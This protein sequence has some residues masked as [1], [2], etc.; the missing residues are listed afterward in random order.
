M[1]L[2]GSERCSHCG[3]GWCTFYCPAS[4]PSS[5]YLGFSAGVSSHHHHHPLPQL[6]DPDFSHF[7]PRPFHP[8]SNT[9][10]VLGRITASPSRPLRLTHPSSLSRAIALSISLFL[11]IASRRLRRLP[12]PRWRAS[13]QMSTPTC[14]AATGTTTVSTSVRCTIFH[15]HPDVTQGLC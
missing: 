11:F 4:P 9:P 15:S 14:P 6:A 8:A 5:L 7:R 1:Y 2:P 12:R 10:G 3:A 13:T